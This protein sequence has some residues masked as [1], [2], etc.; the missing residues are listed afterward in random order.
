MGF[1]NRMKM[2]INL[3]YE[4]RKNR[5]MPSIQPL[6]TLTNFTIETLH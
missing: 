6:I 1:Q 5:K 2:K 3:L 4:Y